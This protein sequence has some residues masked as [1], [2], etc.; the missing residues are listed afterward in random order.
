[1]AFEKKTFNMLKTM[2]I[3]LHYM[4]VKYKNNITKKLIKYSDI[5][6]NNDY[7]HI[8]TTETN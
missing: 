6:D 8:K 7:V 4:L 2:F 1:M 3:K 5:Q